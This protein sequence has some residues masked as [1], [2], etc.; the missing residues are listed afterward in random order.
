MARTIR[1]ITLKGYKSIHILEDFELRGINVLIG[2]NGCGKSN[3]VGFFYLLRELVE[4]RLEKAVNKAGGADT[5]LYLG[6]KVTEKIEA[7][8]EFG[9]G[10]YKFTLEPTVDNRLIFGDERIQWADVRPELEE[11]YTFNRSIGMGHGESKLKEKIEK[12]TVDKDHSNYIYKAISSWTV[13]HFH[14]TSETA[15]MRR[16]SSAGDHARLRP[17]AGNIAAFLNFLREDDDKSYKLIVDAVKLV[18]PFFK[19][20]AFRPK[21]RN[22]DEVLQLEWTQEGS[23][24]AFRPSQLSDGTL[25]FIALATALLQPDPPATILIDEPELGLHPF[26]L[27]MLGNLILQ[28]EERTQLVVSTQSAPLLN[29][30]EPEQIIVVE[31]HEGESTFRR[32]EESDLTAWLEAYTLGELWQKNIYGG[33]P[34]HE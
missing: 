24:Y 23:D 9:I 6:P 29:C 21:K 8:L 25:R 4:R 18:A 10:A 20:F 14:D 3:F 27:E 31:R 17:D 26:A 5:Q 15:A 28:A 32:L 11:S 2:S 22:D 12:E 19:D 1:K 13:Y 7:R 34:V 33:G 30:F 16:P